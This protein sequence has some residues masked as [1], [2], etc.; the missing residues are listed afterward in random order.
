MNSRRVLSVLAVTTRGVLSKAQRVDTG[1][2]ACASHLR[3]GGRGLKASNR[4]FTLLLIDEA[5]EGGG[6]VENNRVVRVELRSEYHTRDID[7]HI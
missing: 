2:P 6:E 7:A 3:K 1:L 5:W 4:A